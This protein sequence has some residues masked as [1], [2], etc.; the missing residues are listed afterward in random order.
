ML[1]VIPQRARKIIREVPKFSPKQTRGRGLDT[2]E[3][4][5]LVE[6]ADGQAE[7]HYPLNDDDFGMNGGHDNSSDEE[8]EDQRSA[9]RARHSQ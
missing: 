4:Q 2:T 6:D 1:P 8:M 3:D 5:R 7:D 9:K